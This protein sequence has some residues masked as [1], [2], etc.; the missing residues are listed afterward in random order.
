MELMNILYVSFLLQYVF[1][2]G[3]C[4]TVVA[5]CFTFDTISDVHESLFIPYGSTTSYWPLLVDLYQFNLDSLPYPMVIDQ[6]IASYFCEDS[7]FH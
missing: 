7:L 1:T 3:L 2:D 4:G 5:K 6:S